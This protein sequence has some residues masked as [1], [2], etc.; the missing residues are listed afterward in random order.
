M[1]FDPD[2]ELIDSPLSR[3][4]EWDG[5]RLVVRIFRLASEPGWSLEVVNDLGTSTV[6]QEVF[7]TD[8]DADTAFRDALAHEGIEVFL[9]ENL[10]GHFRSPRLH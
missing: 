3:S 2:L 4:V 7:T 8:R 6:W 5:V 9:D 1:D 10:E